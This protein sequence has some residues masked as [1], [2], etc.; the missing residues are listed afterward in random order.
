[1]TTN[2][3]A[4][5]PSSITPPAFVVSYPTDFTIETTFN[6]GS[7]ELVIPVWY[8]LGAA[9]DSSKDQRDAI[10]LA[11]GSAPSICEA[12]DAVYGWGATT[13]TKGVITR[14]VMDA[15]EY[16]G[17]QFL[18]DVITNGPANLSTIMDALANAI[19]S[20]GL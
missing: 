9:Q 14:I 4:W 20:A 11:L 8:L 12:L 6:R 2:V 16:I 18:V 5:P 15:Q 19:T 17:L 10:S 3:Y 7:D 1:M 13:P